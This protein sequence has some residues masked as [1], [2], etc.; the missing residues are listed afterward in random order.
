MDK[1]IKK[2]QKRLSIIRRRKTANMEISIK[3]QLLI[4]EVF[5]LVN[6]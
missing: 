3:W 5:A 2:Y 1:E 4:V 6:N